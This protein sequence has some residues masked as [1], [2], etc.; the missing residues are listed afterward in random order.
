MDVEVSERDGGTVVTALGTILDAGNAERFKHRLERLVDGGV[1]H[2]VLDLSELRF[3][4]SSGLGAIVA[5]LKRIAGGVTLVL[6][7]SASAVNDV[8]A[9]TRM[10]RLFR[11]V[12]SVDAALVEEIA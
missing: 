5:T 4:D 8:F 9:L 3:I 12:D 10:D 11:I 1:T 2:L 7:P 6:N